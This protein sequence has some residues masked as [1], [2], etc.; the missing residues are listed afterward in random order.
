MAKETGLNNPASYVAL[1][2][3]GVNMDLKYAACI[4]REDIDS[5]H[6]RNTEQVC[7]LDLLPKVAMATS[8]S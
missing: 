6:H 4:L 7:Y 3:I 5:H 1:N 2:L 8:C